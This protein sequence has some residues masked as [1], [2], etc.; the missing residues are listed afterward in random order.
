MSVPRHEET[1]V[2][3]REGIVRGLR[4]QRERERDLGVSQRPH[5]LSLLHVN[6]CRQTEPEL[7]GDAGDAGALPSAIFV[8]LNIEVDCDMGRL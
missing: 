8:A 3:T 4:A 1:C 2:R 7:A 5:L 6:F